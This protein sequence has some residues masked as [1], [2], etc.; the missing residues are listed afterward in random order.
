MHIASCTLF[1]L[2]TLCIF[3]WVKLCP[4]THSPECLA[5]RERE[6]E[7][8]KNLLSLLHSLAILESL[9]RAQVFAC[10]TLDKYTLCMAITNFQSF[11]SR[12]LIIF[13]LN[14][15]W[16]NCDFVLYT[17]HSGGTLLLTDHTPCISNT[18]NIKKLCEKHLRRTKPKNFSVLTLV[19]GRLMLSYP[20]HSALTLSRRTS[21]FSR[22]PCQRWVRIDRELSS[23]EI[24][25]R[26]R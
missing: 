6:R 9:G 11:K 24:D 5:K 20:L 17:S 15:S 23:P 7:R 26:R 25:L 3:L 22:D 8:K 12:E 18:K 13:S 21:T 16:S 10:A 2:Q 14:S 4:P 1:Y 19:R